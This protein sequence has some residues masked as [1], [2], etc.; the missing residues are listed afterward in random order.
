[1]R[2]NAKEVGDICILEIEGE[3]D[4]EHSAQLKKAIVKARDEFAKHFI[5][6]LSRVSFIDSTGLGVLISLMRH[7]NENSGRLKLAGLQDEVR[8]IF[9]ITRLY[10]VFDLVPSA[11]DAL[12][13]FQ[14]KK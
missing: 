7:L 12:K 11:E 3:V 1:M 8:S 14:K 13:D 9:E 5:L 6:D 10:K 4:A 2:V